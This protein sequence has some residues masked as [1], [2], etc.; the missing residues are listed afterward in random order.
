MAQDS[1]PNPGCAQAMVT[2]E[3]DPN[4]TRLSEYH[5]TLK[6]LSRFLPIYI[7]IRRDD[8]WPHLKWFHT[9]LKVDLDA[10]V[11]VAF[12]A[13]SA[14]EVN[15]MLRELNEHCPNL[16]HIYIGYTTRV[17]EQ[18][19]GPQTIQTI[20]DLESLLWGGVDYTSTQQSATRATPDLERFTEIVK[21]GRERYAD[22]FLDPSELPQYDP[23]YLESLRPIHE[24]WNSEPF[25]PTIDVVEV[26]VMLADSLSQNPRY[27]RESVRFLSD[28]KPWLQRPSGPC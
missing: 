25:T 23:A 3:S 24:H 1:N 4:G 22:H 15:E 20:Q 6:V 10:I 19:Q 7:P 13:W 26:P 18:G 8:A 11:Q 17:G 16:R 12:Y 21:G 28:E 2:R 9:F 5:R 14:H 27:Y